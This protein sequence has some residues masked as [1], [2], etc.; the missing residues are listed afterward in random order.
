MYLSNPEN[1]VQLRSYTVWHKILLDGENIDK[2]DKF[3]AIRDRPIQSF[4]LQ[5]L[6]ACKADTIHQNII[7]QFFIIP[8]HHQNFVLYSMCDYI[9]K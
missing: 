5:W 2:F 8:T 3:F 9:N 1:W 7:H 4:H 6:F